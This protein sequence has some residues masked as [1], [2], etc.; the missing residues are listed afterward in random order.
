M[1]GPSITICQDK[2][3][4]A[5]GLSAGGGGPTDRRSRHRCVWFALQRGVRRAPYA[6]ACTIA[7]P[8]F[9]TGIC[10]TSSRARPLSGPRTCQWLS[11]S[12]GERCRPQRP[13]QAGLAM[14]VAGRSDIH[15]VGNCRVGSGGAPPA[16]RSQCLASQ[17]LGCV[18]G[19]LRAAQQR[20]G[21]PQQWNLLLAGGVKALGAF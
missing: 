7:V 17:S 18:L 2:R 19:Y 9:R 12:S 8:C 4:D 20:L 21:A 1:A 13:R 14:S 5:K 3:Q 6:A 11:S 10:I 16:I 15:R